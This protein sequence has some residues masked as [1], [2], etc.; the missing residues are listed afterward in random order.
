M[1]AVSLCVEEGRLC[2]WRSPTHQALVTRWTWMASKAPNTHARR[3]PGL[4]RGFYRRARTHDRA[5]TQVRVQA[6]GRV[7]GRIHPRAR[8]QAS[9][10]KVPRSGASP[11]PSTPGT[12]C[13]PPFAP[14]WAHC[15][16]PA[17]TARSVRC[18]ASARA[19]DRPQALTGDAERLPAGRQHPQQGAAS[20]QPFGQRRHP[21]DQMLAVVQPFPQRMRRGQ[22]PQLRY[23][24]PMPA[25]PELRLDPVLQR[26]GSESSPRRAGP[27]SATSLPLSRHARVSPR[28]WN[29]T[30]AATGSMDRSHR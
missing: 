16:S 8:R 7:R 25:L 11:L 3:P 28:I 10:P 19:A 17:T 24:R 29:R 2:Q 5:R 26:A 4:T 18:R 23:G 12:P 9:R 14:P 13:M 21:V 22:L 6:L 20:Q 30:K 27:P 15:S 1:W